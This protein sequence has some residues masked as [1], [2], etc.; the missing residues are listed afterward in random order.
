MELT[1][2]SKGQTYKKTF[3]TSTPK[4]GNEDDGLDIQIKARYVRQWHAID[5]VAQK[6]TFIAADSMA[7]HCC[8]HLACEIW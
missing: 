5:P 8:T 2:I 4:Q 3:L 6:V 1:N 7:L